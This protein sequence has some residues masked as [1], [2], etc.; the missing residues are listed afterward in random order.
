MH[1][2]IDNFSRRILA[3]QLCAKLEPATTVAVLREAASEV[4]VKG[5]PMLVTDSGV[6]NVNSEVDALVK[7]SV[8]RRVLAL[9]EVYY[10]N[11]V[12]LRAAQSSR[13]S[14]NHYSMKDED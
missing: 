7:D 12:K 11:S 1:A 8:I 5:T 9:V 13:G 14:L 2:V 4:V 10:S 6:E 3:W